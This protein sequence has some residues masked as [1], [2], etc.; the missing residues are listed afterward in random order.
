MQKRMA[1]KQAQQALASSKVKNRIEKQKITYVAVPVRG[2][3]GQKGG[4]TT[5]MKVNAATGVPTGEVYATKGE[6]T[7]KDGDTIKLGGDPTLYFA[8]TGSKL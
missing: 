6:G 5:V 3:K 1:E 2:E 7:V 8:T 4:G